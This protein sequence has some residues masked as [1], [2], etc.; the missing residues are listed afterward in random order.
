MC[1]RTWTIHSHA[2]MASSPRRV[3]SNKSLVQQFTPGVLFDIGTHW[4]VD[5]DPS[6][7]YYS[8]KD[9]RDSLSQ[10]LSLTWGTSYEDWQL[11]LTQTYAT[12][13]APLVE[14]GAQ[15]DT[16]SYVTGLTASYRFNSLHVG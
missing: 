4:T 15:T 1:I 16:E 3:K 9:L 14:T 2:A 7:T 10:S 5:Y 8:S 13:S 11:G 6:L 12:A